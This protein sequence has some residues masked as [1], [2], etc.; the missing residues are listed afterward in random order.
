MRA[1]TIAA[2]V[3]AGTTSAEAVARDALA[4]IAAY[5]AV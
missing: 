2:E 4:R 5:D 3:A 1:R